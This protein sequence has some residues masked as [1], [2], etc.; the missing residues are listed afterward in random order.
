ML[1][2]DPSNLWLTKNK[3]FDQFLFQSI[4]ASNLVSKEEKNIKEVEI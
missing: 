3:A 2:F 4:Q 1:G